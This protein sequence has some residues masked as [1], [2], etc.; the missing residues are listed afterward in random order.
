MAEAISGRV[1][2]PRGEAQ[3]YVSAGGIHAPDKDDGYR[4]TP[5]RSLP[6]AWTPKDAVPGW[7]A[8][9][10][11]YRSDQPVNGGGCDP[12]GPAAAG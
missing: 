4:Q 11:A 12:G 6:E 8:H 10:A 9:D 1:S 7:R 5:L 2:V 3:N